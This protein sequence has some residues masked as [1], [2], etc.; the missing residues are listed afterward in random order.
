MQAALLPD[1][2]VVKV[3][4]DD[5]RKFLNGL[6]TCDLGKV[7]P[8]RAGF[9]AL[10][11]PQGK[12]IVDFLLAEAPA[13]DGGGFFLDCPRA[14][15]PALVQRLNF[16]KLRAKI[17]VEDLSETLGVLAIWG[18]EAASEY[19]LCYAD[20]RLP[21]LGLRCMLPPHLAG[22]AAADLGAAL[23][24]PAVY[25]ARRI[26]LGV[27]R[28][29]LDFVY[30]DAFP[31][32]TDMDQLGGV[33]FDKGC[34][35]G[36]EVVS[37]IEHRGTARTGGAGGV[38]RLRSRGRHAGE[39]RRQDDRHARLD[40][41]R[42][43]PCHAAPRPRRRR[44]GRRA[45]ARERRRR[46]AAGQ[47]GLGAFCLAG[48]SKGGG[49]NPPLLHPDGLKRCPWPKQDP[50]YV[51]YH[52]EEWGVPEYDD[53]ALFE[54]LV[55]D[56]FQAGL[57]WITILR[58]RDNFRRAFDGFVPEKI[59]RYAPKKVARLMQDVG[60]VR[61]RLK[62]EGAVL[63]AR[64]YLDVMEKGPGF[65]RLLWEFVDGKPKVNHFRSTSQVPAETALSRRVSK[66]L[67]GRG[68]KFVG[69]SI[70][71]AFMQATGMVNDHLVSCHR[72]APLA[73]LA[74]R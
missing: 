21:A 57:S 13:A 50:L 55:L 1:R 9:A 23:V 35:V 69:P 72:H 61:N 65:S 37:R 66:E 48:R 20:P 68:F 16:Y 42:S 70:V 18:G 5:A 63:S 7:T 51:A 39:R 17:I 64:A 58:K 33:D 73:K 34:F 19:G 59:A 47:T 36:Q 62:I 11:T 44:A 31:H 60:I 28:G 45:L 67:A 22:N 14:L 32:E 2:G 24:E 10:L 56:G 52:D 41:A 8:A 46:A 26:A 25:E 15:A 38:R 27:P 53:R 49:M 6:I 3:A 54:K 71:Y 43:R 40:G 12:I 29:G 4:G 74:A 30:G